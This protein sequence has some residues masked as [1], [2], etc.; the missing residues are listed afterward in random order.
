M[1]TLTTET[2]REKIKEMLQ[3]TDHPV[4]RSSSVIL[5]SCEL[6]GCRSWPPRE[7]I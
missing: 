2:R 6:P 3:K 1:N 4:T 7:D 5:L